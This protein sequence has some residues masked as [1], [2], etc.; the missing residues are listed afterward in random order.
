VRNLFGRKDKL[1]KKSEIDQILKKG[2]KFDCLTFKILYARNN[3]KNDRLGILVSKK[4]GNA[5]IRNKTKRIFREIFRKIRNKYPP[6][7]DVLIQPRPGIDLKS[8][9]EVEKCFEKWKNILKN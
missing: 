5:V 1:K 2:R 9:E 7:F 3:E 4:I 6:F 8:N